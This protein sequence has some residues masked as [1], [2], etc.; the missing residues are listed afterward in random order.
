MTGT[1]S[2]GRCA[3]VLPVQVLITCEMACYQHLLRVTM[4]L[5]PSWQ[6][7]RHAAVCPASLTSGRQLDKNLRGTMMILTP[8][9]I[10]LESQCSLQFSKSRGRSGALPISNVVLDSNANLYG[11][12]SDET[13]LALEQGHE[14][15]R[16]NM[17]MFKT[18]VCGC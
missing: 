3:G 14:R 8:V 12:V 15:K 9:R 4:N 10:G 18:S 13:N 6:M 11:V 17:D 1:R 2:G 7:G 5:N 16:E